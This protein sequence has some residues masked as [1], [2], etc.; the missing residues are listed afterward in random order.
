MLSA[1]VLI[2]R[3][4]I[5]IGIGFPTE[6]SNHDD[7]VKRVP[8]QTTAPRQRPNVHPIM[9]KSSYPLMH[10]CQLLIA[11][12]AR[13]TTSFAL[14]QAQLHPFLTSSTLGSLSELLFRNRRFASVFAL[15][16]LN[17]FKFLGVCFMLAGSAA[18]MGEQ[19][20]CISGSTCSFHAPNRLAEFATPCGRQSDG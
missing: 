9:K 8:P 14:P 16:V 17:Q 7:S 19:L 3:R 1:S 4:C 6:G 20:C 5:R 18:E 15:C 12:C 2:Y 13:F 10:L 11:R